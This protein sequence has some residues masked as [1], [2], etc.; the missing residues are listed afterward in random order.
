MPCYNR[1]IKIDVFA[2][3]CKMGNLIIRQDSCRYKEDIS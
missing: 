2:L 3:S 1:D